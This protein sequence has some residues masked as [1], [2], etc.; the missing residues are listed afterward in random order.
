MW[1]GWFVEVKEKTVF[2]GGPAQEGSAQLMA[3]TLVLA[4]DLSQNV[5]LKSLE[6]G[7]VPGRDIPR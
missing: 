2:W 5:S 6:H 7:A 3:T 1:R 4:W